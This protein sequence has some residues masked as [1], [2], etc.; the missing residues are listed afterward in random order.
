MKSNSLKN[1]VIA[2]VGPT[3]S[4]KTQYAVKLA[5]EINGEVISADSRYVYRELNVGTA[6]PSIE[7]MEEIKHHLID[8]V[9]PDFD[10]SVG[11]YVKDA[12]KCIED[13]ISRGKTPIIAGGTGLYFTVLFENFILPEV[14]PDW[15]LRNKLEQLDNENLWNTLINLDKT[16]IDF[17]IDK[18]DRKKVVRTIEILKHT[19]KTLKEIRQKGDC[20]YDVEW[21][22]LNFERDTLYERI[23]NRVDRMIESGLIEETKNLIDKWGRIHNIID[24]I[25]YKEILAYLDEEITLERAVDLLKQN[26]RRYAKRQL[27]WFRKNN[28]IKWNVYPEI[29][30]K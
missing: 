24:T 9:N 19:G 13:I 29:L 30:K 25:G 16:A 2:V 21:I 10:Y 23:N 20:E 22:G 5:K 14:V 3:A 15:N 12:K 18:N 1:K 28:N 6:K 7:E 26:S 4:G 17:N 11:L 27:T 8:I